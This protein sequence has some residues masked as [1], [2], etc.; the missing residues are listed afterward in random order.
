VI[1]RVAIRLLLCAA[2][3]SAEGYSAAAQ[4]VNAH[5]RIDSSV[6]LVGDRIHVKVDLRHPRGLTI[7]PMVGDTVEGFVV[8]GRS[9]LEH[10]TDTTSRAEFVLSRYDSG[11][12]AIPPLPFLYFVPNDTA[13]HV[14]VTNQLVVTMQT[15]PPDTTKGMRDIKPVIDIPLSWEDIALY[16]VIGLAVVGL[17]VL[18]YW[19]WKKRKRTLSGEVYTPP[20]RPAHVV[21]LEAL[22]DLKAKKLWQQGLVKEYY[23]DLTEIFRRYFEHRYNVPALEETT[24]EILSGLRDVRVDGGLL[25]PAEVILRRADLVKFAKATP[26][27]TDHEDAYRG[28]VSFVDKTKMLPMTP[29]VSD[30]GKAKTDVES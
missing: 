1:S 28:V 5:A 3:L 7:Q 12:A 30:D 9:G 26:T 18:G 27:A 21:A 11:D 22:A 4:Q 25:G 29:V 19:L 20:Q 24:D 23:S 13:S 10:I 17:C 2:A 16:V 6:Y 15:V 8:L 14:A